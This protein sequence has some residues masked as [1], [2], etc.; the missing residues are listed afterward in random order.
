MQS[1]GLPVQPDE[2][3]AF[4][5]DQ[6]VFRKQLVAG[7]EQAAVAPKIGGSWL[8]E[9]SGKFRT[10][11]DLAFLHENLYGPLVVKG[12]QTVEDT[13]A[14]MDARMDGMI[15]SDHGTFLTAGFHGLA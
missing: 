8:E 3:P 4:P 2:R 1:M 10:W 15:V 12:I 9:T 7:D 11:E 13:H 6:E 5:F 14:A